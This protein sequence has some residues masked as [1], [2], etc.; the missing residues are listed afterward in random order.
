MFIRNIPD[1]DAARIGLKGSPT[2]V[3]RSFVPERKKSGVK[4]QEE[5]DGESAVKLVQLLGDAHVI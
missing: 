3:K 5:T 1:I 4:I 2:H